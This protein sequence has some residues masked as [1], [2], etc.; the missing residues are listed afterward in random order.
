MNN[1]L[2]NHDAT[3]IKID[4]IKKSLV[5]DLLYL[6]DLLR[7]I[8]DE[9]L[10]L[11]KGYGSFREW[12]KNADLDMSERQCF[13]LIQIVTRAEKLDIPRDNLN[14]V[15]ISK[16]K[17]IFS[18]PED[19]NDVVKLL[20]IEAET[21]SLKDI[22]DMVAYEK[23]NEWVYKTLKLPREF[24]DNGWKLAINRVKNESGND[25]IPDWSC[26]ERIFSDYLSGPSDVTETD[27][28]EASFEDQYETYKISPKE[29]EQS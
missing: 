9:H 23:D 6:G 27:I 7:Q 19:K 28:I 18:L 13:Y 21:T 3:F 29:K 20:L 24:S 1:T 4:Q 2:T 15:K 8:Q 10:Y 14:S 25:D 12:I 22:K 26:I 16:L 11:E 5:I 17:E